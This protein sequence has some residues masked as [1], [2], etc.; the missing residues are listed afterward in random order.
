LSAVGQSGE[1]VAALLG[2]TRRTVTEARARW[3]R[4]AQRALA[5]GR[6]DGRPPRADAAYVRRLLVTATRDPRAV[7]FAFT[8]W[9]TPRLAAYMARATGVRLTARWV[10]E[11]LH[12]R[13]PVWRRTKRTT[14]HLA[15]PDEVAAMRRRTSRLKK[16]PV[17]P[18]P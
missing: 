2:V 1:Q 13:G 17:A 9:T 14:R 18:T 4:G 16:G 3:R 6:R 7:G 11:L 5:E 10:R 15:D 8:R 12:R